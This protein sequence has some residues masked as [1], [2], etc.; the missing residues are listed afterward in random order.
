MQQFSPTSVSPITTLLEAIRLRWRWIGV[1][2]VICPI[3]AVIADKVLVPD[4]RSRARLMMQEGVTVNPYLKDMQVEWTVKNRLPVI[5]SVLMARETLETVLR[6][7]GDI[8]KTMNSGEADMKVREFAKQITI[9]GLGGGVVQIDVKGPQA[10]SVYQALQTLMAK[11]VEEM[12]RPQ[13]QAL[14]DS[15]D[16]LAKQAA[17]I[18]GELDDLEEKIKTFKRANA[19]SLPDLYRAQLSTHGVVLG[20]LTDAETDLSAIKRKRALMEQRLETYDP[21]TELLEQRLVKAR[22]ELERMRASFSDDH[23]RLAGARASVAEIEQRLTAERRKPRRVNAGQLERIARD[24]PTLAQ[25]AMPP[26]ANQEASPLMAGEIQQ[27]KKIIADQETLEEKVRALQERVAKSESDVSAYGQQEPLLDRLMR[28]HETKEKAYQ[29][30][31]ER[32][33]DALV[34]RALTLNDEQSQVWVLEA[35]TLP[36]RKP[37]LPPPLA[38]VAGVFAGIVLAIGLILGAEIFE[39]RVRFPQEAEQIVG[40]PVIGSLPLGLEE[41]P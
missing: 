18:K 4:V 5:Q 10:N 30:L 27:Y 38:A 41:A 17:R 13:K 3:I 33:E 12:L 8:T 19:A 25:P 6:K 1:M 39:R 32:Y 37:A 21:G 14:D 34:T 7:T 23:P 35:P 36:E 11:L 16:F 31:L 9:S 29:R 24:T 22:E 28:D 40:A 26:G 20:N 2:M 15:V